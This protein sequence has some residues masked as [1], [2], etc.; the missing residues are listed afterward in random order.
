M[1]KKITHLTSAHSRYDTRIFIK[2]CSSL[3]ANGYSVSLVVADGLGNEV[4]NGVSIV[5]V[6]AKTGGRLSRMTKTVNRV[7]EKAKEL[8]ADIYHFHD[9]E[10]IP[11]GLKL[12]KFGKKVLFDSHEDVPQQ[13]LGKFYLSRFSKLV[14]SRLFAIYENWACPKLDGVVAATPH[15]RDK[16]L[17]FNSHSIDICNYPILEEFSAV[18]SEG[19][20]ARECV[21]IGSLDI[22]RGVHEIVE[23][24]SHTENAK[25]NLGGKFKDAKLESDVKSLSGWEYVQELGF[26]SRDE[27]K[28]VFERSIVGLVTLHPIPNYMEALPVKLFEYMSAGL[29]VIASDIP[30]WKHIVEKAECG[31][32]VDPYDSSAIAEAVMFMIENPEIARTM[33]INGRKAVLNQFNWANEEKKLLSFYERLGIA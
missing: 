2:M 7:F 9:P 10:L 1:L 29:P 21:Y 3:A 16:F 12:K 20:K 4:K 28:V 11:I 17:K 23:A 5:D 22:A 15:I 18:S 24:M 19:V 31:I 32:C 30:L 13:I 27:I 26:L 6:G 14:I 33:G 25:L 8:D